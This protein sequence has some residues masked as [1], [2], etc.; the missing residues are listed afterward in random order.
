MSRVRLAAVPVL[1]LLL[2]AC[3]S[4]GTPQ[5]AATPS[6]SLSASPSSSPSPSVPAS[7]AATPTSTL[8]S[9][10]DQLVRV[11]VRNGAVVGGAQRVR[12]RLGDVVRLVVTSDVA[13]EV[14]LHSY[15]KSVAVTAGGTATLTFKATIPGVIM[16]ELEKAELTLIRFQIQ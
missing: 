5:G 15:D 10:V 8:P 14:H 9:G 2:G 16:A 6:P 13:D 11:A 4:G 7:S 12:V 3:S 1:A